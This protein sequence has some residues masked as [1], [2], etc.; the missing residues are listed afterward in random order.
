MEI[1]VVLERGTDDGGYLAW[2]VDLPGC[3]T[4]SPTRDGAIGKVTG[5]VAAF[6]AMLA[7]HGV[8]VDDLPGGDDLTVRVVDEV[9]TPGAMADVDTDVVL[10]ADRDPLT[11]GDWARL[12][13]WS[14]AARAELLAV[15]A[16]LDGEDLDHR[17]E[18]A[19]RSVREVLLH[20]GLVELFYAVWTFDLESTDGVADLLRWT[21][22]ATRRRMAE[23]VADGEE[24]LTT[25]RWAGA[26]RP[27]GWS[28]RKAA[29]RLI[30]HD[31][32]HT[33]GLR[34]QLEH[35]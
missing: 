8:P 35:R 33:R 3:S 6:V 22:D 26:D 7:D 30:W 13:S 32:L 5:A 21:R 12:A 24:Q 10:D 23:L 20:T 31:V 29:R 16:G 19:P 15:L 18:G 34:R 14:D 17:P 4:R 9:E 27:E 2:V 11:A 1:E 28:A 25:A